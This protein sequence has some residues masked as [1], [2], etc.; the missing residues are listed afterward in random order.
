M[1]KERNQGEGDRTSARRYDRH[2]QDFVSGGKVD[3][4][5]QKA[6]EFVAA[7]PEEAKRDER[8][9]K[10]GPNP[11]GLVEQI[12]AKGRAMFERIRHAVHDRHGR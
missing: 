12:V 8:K 5:A 9:A 2:L 10:A 6:R 4:A 1:D 7:H 11:R 3:E